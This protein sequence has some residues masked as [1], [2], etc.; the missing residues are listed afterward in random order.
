[1]LALGVVLGRM[2]ALGVVLGRMLALG[3]VPRVRLLCLFEVGVILRVGPRL[4]L[5]VGSQPWPGIGP[6]HECC[7]GTQQELN[8]EHGDR[9]EKAQRMSCRSQH[10][11]EYA[12]SDQ[13]MATAP[14][15]QPCSSWPVGGEVT[16]I[17][18]S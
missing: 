15:V 11:G 18:S 7:A 9:K 1:M 10:A 5:H 3:V 16:G 6:S 17:Y 12:R 8:D 14:L 2:L 13:G 4:I